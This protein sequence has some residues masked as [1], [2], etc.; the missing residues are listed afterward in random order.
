METTPNTA[1]LWR[2]DD[3]IAVPRGLVERHG[4]RPWAGSVALFPQKSLFHGLRLVSH[5]VK[6]SVCTDPVARGDVESVN[7]GSSTL[8]TDS[9]ERLQLRMTHGSTGARLWVEPGES[10]ELCLTMRVSTNA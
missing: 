10:G 9:L 6:F 5:R 3:L 2:V 7:W 1:P 8:H 4:L